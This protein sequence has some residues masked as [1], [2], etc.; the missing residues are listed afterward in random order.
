MQEPLGSAVQREAWRAS[1]AAFGLL[2]LAG[3]A[4]A[5]QESAGAEGH[6]SPISPASEGVAVER[7][8]AGADEA[9][10]RP[11]TPT[12]TGAQFDSGSDSEDRRLLS[13]AVVAEAR[14]LPGP[15]PLQQASP[16]VPVVLPVALR[17][18]A[19]N[20]S[21]EAPGWALTALRSRDVAASVFGLLDESTQQS[22]VALGCTARDALLV[23][24]CLD[25][26]YWREPDAT[27]AAAA[28]V[29]QR[30]LQESRRRSPMLVHRGFVGAAAPTE[31]TGSE[32]GA[33]GEAWVGAAWARWGRQMHDGS[34]SLDS[35]EQ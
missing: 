34:I 29:A 4:L 31:E 27:L 11:T 26:K 1:A 35:Q 18:G 10:E 22:L 15:E 6:E 3:E 16:A 21:A 25:P 24:A 23:A 13:A 28:E 8:G 2:P 19:S 7:V 12:P 5:V 14:R 30:T 17:S 33:G 32:E 20:S 9:A